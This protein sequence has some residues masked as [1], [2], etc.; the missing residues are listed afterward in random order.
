MVDLGRRA[1]KQV[2]CLLTDMDQPLGGT[3]G[4]ALEIRE[5]VETITGHGPDDLVEPCWT[6]L[7]AC[8]R[9]RISMSISKKGGDVP[10]PCWWTDRRY[11][12]TSVGFGRRAG[13]PISRACHARLSSAR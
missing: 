3:V 12:R 13:I 1:E 7:R 6:R 2:V 10:K 11:A 4:N 8:S 5:A 9:S